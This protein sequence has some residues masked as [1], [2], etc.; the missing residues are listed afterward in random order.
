MKASTGKS[1]MKWILA[2]V[3]ASALTAH[4]AIGADKPNIVM[5]MDDEV[6]WF[7][8]G[9]YHRRIMSGKTP[10]TDRLAAEGM[11][12]TDYY[13]EASC[14]AGRANFITGMIPMRTGMA[15]FDNIVGAVI[16]N[17]RRWLLTK[18]PSSE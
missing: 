2:H 16:K 7:N 15:Q 12:F 11:L 5:I 18:T 4:P 13:A 3:V 9:V 10:N 1:V 17:S 8:I 14:T 6:G